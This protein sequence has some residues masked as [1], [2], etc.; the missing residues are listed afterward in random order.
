MYDPFLLPTSLYLPQTPLH[1]LSSTSP[2]SPN[3]SPSLSPLVPL[4]SSFHPHHLTFQLSLCRL[5]P[6]LQRLPSLIV[7]TN[8]VIL[9]LLILFLPNLYPYLLYHLHLFLL[10]FFSNK[11]STFVH[12]GPLNP[13]HVYLLFLPLLRFSSQPTPSH[14]WS[15]TAAILFPLRLFHLFLPPSQLLLHLF[16]HLP[17]LI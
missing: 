10:L 9:S 3:S 8:V 14:S 6:Y 12:L 1:S 13:L 7:Y 15:I 2:S 4:S 17:L 5:S 11:S 16:H